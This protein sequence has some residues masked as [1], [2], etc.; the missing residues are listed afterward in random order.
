[1]FDIDYFKNINDTYGHKTG[2]AVL[3]AV[4]KTA[5]A[6]IR[7]SDYLVR[8]GGEEFV[9]VL[10]ET[11]F[12]KAIEL[13]E[14]LRNII[15]NLKITCEEHTVTVTASFGV[16]AFKKGLNG[17]TIVKK[18]DEML[19]EAKRQGRNRTKPDLRLCLSLPQNIP[20]EELLH[21]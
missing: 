19:Y 9:I 13:A 2:D 11:K 20:T 3:R 16:S 8:Y 10:P 7:K 1:M 5:Q 12:S 4:A 14:R 15:Q 6:A 17:N 18:A 21:H